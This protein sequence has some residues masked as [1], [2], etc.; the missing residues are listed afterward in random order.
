SGR[1]PPDLSGGAVTATRRRVRP[2]ATR[3]PTHSI[4]SPVT[5]SSRDRIARRA[6]RTAYRLAVAWICR[7]R[8]LGE[9]GEEFRQTAGAKVVEAHPAWLDRDAR[10][11]VVHGSDLLLELGRLISVKELLHPGDVLV[12]DTVHDPHARG[13][14]HRQ[15][16]GRV[17]PV[18]SVD[19]Q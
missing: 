14:A 2:R 16:L 9:V 1:D 19:A 7:L 8:A 6:A 11:P 4:R 5:G 17:G 3:R 13:A 18:A 15:R 12:G 10:H